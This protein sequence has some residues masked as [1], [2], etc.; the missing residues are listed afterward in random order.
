MLGDLFPRVADNRY[1]GR[2]LGLWLF[3]LMLLR[4]VMGSDIM[5]NASSVA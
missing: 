1:P 2:K 3:A 4:I 5:V